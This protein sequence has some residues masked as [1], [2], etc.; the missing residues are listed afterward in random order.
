MS[1]IR[2]SVDTLIIGAGLVGSSVAMH[3][4]KLGAQNVRV[5]DFDLEGSFSSSELNAGGVRATWVQ[6][7][8]IQLSKLSIEYFAS[9]ADECGYRPCGYLWLHSPE[10][11]NAA[12]KARE[13]QLKQGWTVEA[14]DLAELRRRVPFIDKTDGLAGAA[15]AP[16]DGLINPNL[17][18]GHFRSKARELGVKFDDRTWVKSAEYVSREK[19]KVHLSVNRFESA[20]S[21]DEKRTF[22]E[23]GRTSRRHETVVYEAQRVINCAG[24][25]SGQIAQI[26]GYSCPTQAVRR[27]VCIF[28]CRDVDLTPY[29]MIVDSSGVYFHPE[30]TNG[31]AG[32]A[33]HEE[34]PGVNYTYD[35]ESFFMDVIWPALYERSTKFERLRHLTG[36]AGLYE[37]SPDESAI[38]GQVEQG[39]AG[40]SGSVFEAHSFS[41]HGVMQCY[42]VGLLLAEKIIRGR[43]E[44]L[45]LSQLSGKRF[46]QGKTVRESLVI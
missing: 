6:P 11:M 39:E 3:L 30:A 33:A 5:I 46:E 37:V 36:W 14:W 27:Q 9:I 40:K 25:W 44:T 29:G 15:F 7:I 19:A 23:S 4:A 42:S 20:L 17:L 12:M 21:L 35:G 41:G 13:E 1:S 38:V 22:L 24:P 45:D 2:E 28:D 10:K 32:Y 34:P 43:Y 8:N 31:L 16:R 18:K 26:L